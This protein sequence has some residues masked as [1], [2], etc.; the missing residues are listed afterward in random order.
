MNCDV[1]NGIT[2]NFII[3]VVTRPIYTQIQIDDINP[4]DSFFGNYYDSGIFQSS[5]YKTYHLN[6]LFTY[7]QAMLNTPYNQPVYYKD[8]YKTLV[9]YGQ[10]EILSICIL[11]YNNNA[12]IG[13]KN[14][15]VTYK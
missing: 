15:I 10:Q 14:I 12:N 5:D 9:T 7:W 3:R 1:S 8:G 13:I 4:N 11:T 2:S 6:E